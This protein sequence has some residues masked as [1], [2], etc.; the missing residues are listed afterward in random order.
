MSILIQAMGIEE[1]E[2]GEQ[3]LSGVLSLFLSHH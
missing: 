2:A 3:I 1:L